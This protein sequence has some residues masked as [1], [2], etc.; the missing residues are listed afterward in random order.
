MTPAPAT[1]ASVSSQASGFKSQGPKKTELRKV[2]P[3]K[4]PYS[5]T[6]T[7]F[8]SYDIREM[9]NHLQGLLSSRPE[10]TL[11][12]LN[13][14]FVRICKYRNLQINEQIE[15]IKI[16]SRGQEI[17]LER[18]EKSRLSIEE[19]KQKALNSN[20]PENLLENSNNSGPG[21]RMPNGAGNGTNGSTSNTSNPKKRRSRKSEKAKKLINTPNSVS[22]NSNLSF[23]D[24]RSIGNSTE[25]LVGL[26]ENSQHPGGLGHHHLQHQPQHQHGAQVQ[27]P[28]VRYAMNPPQSSSPHK[29]HA[30]MHQQ[31]IHQHNLQMQ[32]QHQQRMQEANQENQMQQQHITQPNQVQHPAQ[33]L[34]ANHSYAHQS[35]SHPH[36]GHLS[37]SSPSAGNFQHVQY[38]QHHQQ[39]MS[40]QQHQQHQQ[41]QHPHLPQR[42]MSSGHLSQNINS[43]AAGMVH[44]SPSSGSFEMKRSVNWVW[45]DF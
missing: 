16:P 31:Q 7:Q 38:Q 45:D 20:H 8:R 42:Q 39:M 5:C 43:P 6:L 35:S 37:H 27:D 32:E 1:P 3:L 11:D 9:R 12:F 40:L 25:N 33:H 14:E 18:K 30:A 10:Y 19:K 36:P 29:Q 13:Q 41:Q 17:L 2:Y 21:G 24:S 34:P 28:N 22:S 26:A 44:H 4:M 15:R 23:S